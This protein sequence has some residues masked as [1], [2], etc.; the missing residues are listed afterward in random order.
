MDILRGR[1]GLIVGVANAHSIAW[2]IAQAAHAA[3]AELAVSVQTERLGRTVRPMCASLDIAV[4][5]PCD[6]NDDAALQAT[7]AYLHARWGRLDFLVHAAAYAPRGALQGRFVD[8]SRDDFAVALQASAYSL[9]ALTRACLPLLSRGQDPSVLTLSYAGAER[10][11][12]NYNVMGPAKAALEACV[13]YLALDL[14]AEGIRVNALRPG[15]VRTL[16]ASAVR[17]LRHMQE[18]VRRDAPLGRNV[19]A[20]EV[21]DA[22]LWLLSSL[23]RGTTGEVVHVDAGYH[24]VGAPGAAPTE[25]PGGP[26][27]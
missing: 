26:E 24:V 11:L 1:C 7:V 17:G 12:P 14:G 9:V 13:R 19:E 16:S 27:S 18:V 25:G 15:P 22:A 20:R 6:L 21:G 5:G 23:G 4:C 10:A 3:G 8:T 2:G